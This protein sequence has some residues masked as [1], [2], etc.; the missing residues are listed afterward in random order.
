MDKVGEKRVVVT[1][2]TKFALAFIWGGEE[3]QKKHKGT[4]DDFYWTMKEWG[5]QQSLANGDDV[6]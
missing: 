6:I 1:M 3:R 4:S 5:T 2:V